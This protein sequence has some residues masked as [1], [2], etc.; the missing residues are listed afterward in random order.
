VPRTLATVRLELAARC[1]DVRIGAGV[2][3]RVGPWVAALLHPTRAAIIT[4][5]RLAR[6][7]GEPLARGLGR[8]G[9]PSFSLEVPP[10]ERQKSLH[11]AEQ[12][13]GAL[14]VGGC[15]RRAVVIALGG[16]VIGDLAGFVAATFMRGIAFVQVPTTLIAQVDASVGG[17]V[18]VD[19]RLAKNAIGAF[20]QPSLVV[21]DLDI[22]ATLPARELRAGM[23]EVIKHGVIA[24]RDLFT[25]L[26][27]SVESILRL[28][29]AALAHIVRRSVEIKA[30]V[31]AQDEREAGLRAILNLGHTVGHAIE[32]ISSYRTVRHGE[33]ISIGM[34]AA[35][36]LGVRLCGFSEAGAARLE[37]LLAAFGLPIR[38]PAGTMLSVRALPAEASAKAGRRGI[39]F[40]DALLDVMKRD[41][42]TLGGRLRMVLPA[43]IGRV[44]IVDD[45]PLPEVRRVL[46]QM[47]FRTK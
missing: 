37:R 20:H 29:R 44:R 17:K 24:D 43:R 7:Y 21:A 5:P 12:L 15:D 35:A 18:A 8:A 25:Y 40:T 9:V 45:V 16:G 26:E 34:V 4:H 38:L 13:L 3:E 42:K 33:A 41:K 22:L 31:V 28:D 47:S 27:R 10:G 6:L 11:R 46:R 23:A 30:R 36:R 32:T 14:L 39:S 2:L 19:H 1:Y